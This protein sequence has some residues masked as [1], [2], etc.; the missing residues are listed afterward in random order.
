M[1]THNAIDEKTKAIQAARKR[2]IE[3]GK[4]IANVPPGDEIVITGT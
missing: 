4:L 3:Y 1:L 2:A